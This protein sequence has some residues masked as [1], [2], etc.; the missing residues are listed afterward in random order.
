MAD[1]AG[2]RLVFR[3]RI[4]DVLVEPAI[5][6]NGRRV[7]VE[8]VRHPGGAA[9]VA[10]DTEAQVCLLR[11]YRHAF[12][13]WLWEL[14]AGRID[15][16]EQP[17]ATARRELAEETGVRA[18]DW[19]SLGTVMPTPGFC[20]EVVHLFLARDLTRAPAAL[21]ADELLEVHWVEFDT[22]VARALS[23]EWSDSKTVIALLRARAR[24]SE[25]PSG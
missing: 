9:V 1:E 20:N 21:E 6:P 22:A 24:L 3:G 12:R 17:V 4:I 11:Q 8:I 19:S 10:I 15:R 5:Y 25:S 18:A 2:A 14:P 16:G 7:D 13:D 23:G